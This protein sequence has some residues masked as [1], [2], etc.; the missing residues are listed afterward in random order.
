MTSTLASWIVYTMWAVWGLMFIDLLVTL[1]Q[2]LIEGP[3][4]PTFVLG[5][6]KDILYYIVPLEF[7]VNMVPIDPTGWI[8]VIAYFVGGLSVMLKYLLDIIG[9]FR[10]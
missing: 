2:S 3:F 7:M 1:F 4:N 5:Y 8:L 9:K 10:N 6:L